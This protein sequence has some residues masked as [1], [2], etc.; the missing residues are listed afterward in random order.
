LG[1][2]EF[3]FFFGCSNWTLKDY[4]VRYEGYGKEHDEWRPGSEM[5]DTDALD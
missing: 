3:R 4:L 5:A 2:V 1:P